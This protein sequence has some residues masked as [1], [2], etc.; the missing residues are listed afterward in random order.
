MEMLSIQSVHIPEV[1]SAFMS[2]VTR[3]NIVAS[4]RNA[5][6]TVAI[7]EGQPRAPKSP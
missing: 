7:A 6:I 2:P 4:F 5:G 1:M 3:L